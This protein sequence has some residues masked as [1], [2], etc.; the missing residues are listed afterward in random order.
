MN[1]KWNTVALIGCG[2]PLMGS[3]G[4]E[5]ELCEA[6]EAWLGL[7]LGRQE[8]AKQECVYAVFPLGGAVLTSL[9]NFRSSAL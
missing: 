3:Y 4:E 8:V 1:P 2:A 7:L 6:L 5:A 9:F